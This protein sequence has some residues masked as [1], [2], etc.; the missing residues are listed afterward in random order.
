MFC[1]V[2]GCDRTIYSRDLCEKHYR[3]VL[4]NGDPLALRRTPG[5]KTCVVH[6][7]RRPAAARGLCHGHY[8]RLIRG[9]ELTDN[10]PLTRKK[11]EPIC[12]VQTCGRPSSAKGLCKTHLTR[13][14]KFGDVQSGKPI[15]TRGRD[16]HIKHGYRV[17]PVPSDYRHLVNGQTMVAEH[18]LLVAIHLRRPL[19]DDESVHHKNGNRLDNRLTNLELWSRWQPQGQRIEDKVAFALELLR[20]YSPDVLRQ[21]PLISSSTPDRIRT[22]VSALRGPCPWPLDD[23]GS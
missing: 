14:Q 22:D 9:S 13:L 5:Q 17:V 10:E 7:C 21:K 8:Q 20:R 11:Q 18:R 19:H 2:D 15:R 23:G 3:R 6:G 12:S 1:S 4:R 16:G